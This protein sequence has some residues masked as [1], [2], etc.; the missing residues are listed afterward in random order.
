MKRKRIQQVVADL[1]MGKQL[2][3]DKKKA[4]KHAKG[5]L[6][7]E[8]QARALKVMK[9]SIKALEDQKDIIERGGVIPLE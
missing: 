5:K 6:E 1:S 8:N 2:L 7:K 9:K 3:K 4:V